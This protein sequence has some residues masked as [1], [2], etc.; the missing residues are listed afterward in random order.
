[1]KKCAVGIMVPVGLFSFAERKKY[2]N[3]ANPARNFCMQKLVVPP[4][5]VLQ[6]VNYSYKSVFAKYP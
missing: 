2:T 5:V 4:C 1:M 6:S 3:P